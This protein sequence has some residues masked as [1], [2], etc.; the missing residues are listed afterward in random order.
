MI[1]SKLRIE[2]IVSSD[3]GGANSLRNHCWSSLDQAFQFCG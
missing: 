2:V 3:V 1:V